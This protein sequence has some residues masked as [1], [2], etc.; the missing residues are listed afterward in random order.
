MTRFHSALLLLLLPA[1]LHAEDK[2]PAFKSKEGRFSVAL[3]DK[4]VEKVNEMKLGDTEVK[5]YVFSVAQKGR[6]FLVTYNDYPKAVIGE[7]GDK[8][9]A[10]VVERNAANLKGKLI[11]NEKIAIG[12][13]KHPG[14]IVRIEMPDSKGLYRA[15]VFLAG[16]RL[17][18]VV[19][20]G[21]DE[22]AKSKAVDDYLNS[23]EIDE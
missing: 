2:P 6:V 14:H 1:V 7:D 3:P 4:P 20:F 16:D 13:K 17:Y 10:G 19:A 23:F 5:M 15:R 9:L 11:A 21:P 22:F 12:K 8:F 18:Q